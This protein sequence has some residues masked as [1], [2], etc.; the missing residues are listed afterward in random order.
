MAITTMIATASTSSTFSFLN[1]V[2]KRKKKII[3]R[4]GSALSILGRNSS[5][6]VVFVAPT[7]RFQS[8]IRY[9]FFGRTGVRRPSLPGQEI[10]K[11]EKSFNHQSNVSRH[12]R[13]TPQAQDKFQPSKNLVRKK[14]KT[15]FKQSQP[16]TCQKFFQVQ[17]LPRLSANLED[18]FSCQ[19]LTKKHRRKAQL[20]GKKVI[21]LDYIHCQSQ[22]TCPSAGGTKGICQGEICLNEF[23]SNPVTVY[24]LV[25]IPVYSLIFV[26]IKLCII[27]EM[28]C[29]RVFFAKIINKILKN[30]L[31]GTFSSL[32]CNYK[33]QSPCV[34]FSYDL[35]LYR[36]DVWSDQ[37]KGNITFFTKNNQTF[38]EVN[39]T[40]FVMV[41]TTSI[42]QLDFFVKR[43]TVS[44]EWQKEFKQFADAI[45]PQ[46]S[47]KAIESQILSVT[48]IN[49]KDK[50][51]L[52]S[53][54]TTSNWVIN[55]ILHDDFLKLQDYI[56]R[57]IQFTRANWMQI[58]HLKNEFNLSIFL[59]SKL[60]VIEL[61]APLRRRQLVP[62]KTLIIPVEFLSP[63]VASLSSFLCDITILNLI[64]SNSK[65][66]VSVI[67]LF[68]Y[69][70]SSPM[71]V[72][73]SLFPFSFL[74]FDPTKPN[75]YSASSDYPPQTYSPLPLSYPPA[76]SSQNS[77]FCYQYLS[78]LGVF[79]FFS[80]L[81]LI[82]RNKLIKRALK[83]GATLSFIFPSYK[84]F[85]IDFFLSLYYSAI[86][87]FFLIFFLS[88]FFLPV[89][90]KLFSS[91]IWMDYLK[92]ECS[93][94]FCWFPSFWWFVEIVLISVLLK[95]E[96]ICQTLFEFAYESLKL[97][98]LLTWLYKIS[99]SLTQATPLGLVKQA[100]SEFWPF[101]VL[102]FPLS[103]N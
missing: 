33:L 56:T 42:S 66:P 39:E 31:Y 95:S 27:N 3:Y 52:D 23:L 96:I 102:T 4:H 57:E 32:D 40:F 103:N 101:C 78:V 20:L 35:N 75:L 93:E 97:N 76:Q 49:N 48:A 11:S 68:N 88:D 10:L 6:S 51:S 22:M 37:L 45:E 34:Y 13:E 91:I 62:E 21:D 77:S 92:T 63:C 30:N 64:D 36:I 94:N 85:D 99:S 74:L 28:G 26:F 8:F 41:L 65:S 61:P 43:I 17:K 38:H 12:A 29:K 54:I 70:I 24:S 90:K 81:V 89:I 2:H 86:Q 46:V 98:W 5:N 47:Y 79:F 60:R 83:Y 80:S 82:F 55:A 58:K 100:L 1:L 87:R 44:A 73:F 9:S 53:T 59:P 18:P 67:S 19:M 50:C 7:G 84:C 15:N 16:K 69:L 25:H 72:V 14:L 71:F